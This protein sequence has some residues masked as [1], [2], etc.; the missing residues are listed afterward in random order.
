MA[1]FE[2]F[3]QVLR[4]F[5][6]MPR[7]LAV[8]C[9]FRSHY[10]DEYHLCFNCSQKSSVKMIPHRE[11]TREELSA[12]MYDIRESRHYAESAFERS[13]L[14]EREESCVAAM[15]MAKN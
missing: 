10:L 8:D 15:A 5:L 9:G 11:M 12:E 3:K 1:I 4:E 13:M 2:A 7:C 14:R 6:G